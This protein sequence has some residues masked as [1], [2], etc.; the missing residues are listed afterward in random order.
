MFR[1][2]WFDLGPFGAFGFESHHLSYYTPLKS[3]FFIV[4]LVPKNHKIDDA[5]TM[6]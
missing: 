6:M 3:W 2:K 5:W 1:P 4:D